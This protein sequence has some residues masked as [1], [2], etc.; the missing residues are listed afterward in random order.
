M[1]AHHLE[2]ERKFEMLDLTRPTPDMTWKIAGFTAQTPVVEDLD[3]TYFD[4][5]TQTLGRHK[6]ALRRRTGG[7]DQGWHIKFDAAGGRHEVTFDLGEGDHIPEAVTDFLAPVLLNEIVEPAVS[8]LT[9][10]VRTVITSQDG[11]DIAEICDDSVTATDFSTGIERRWHEWEIELLDGGVEDSDSAQQ[12]FEAVEK[13][14][15]EAGAAPSTSSAK[16]AR[17]LGA[18]AEF[19][20]RRISQLG[21]EANPKTGIFP[22]PTDK[23]VVLPAAHLLTDILQGFIVKLAQADLLIRAG[24]PDSTHQGR[25]AARQLRSVIKFMAQPY[26]KDADSKALLKGLADGL[27][28]YAHEL[29]P[30]R[31]GELIADLLAEGLENLP[32]GSP[33]HPEAL[34]QLLVAEDTAHLEKALAYITSVTRRDLQADLVQAGRDI[35]EYCNLP[36]NPDNYINKVAKRLRKKLAKQMASLVA[37]LPQDPQG[38]ASAAHLDEQVHDVR[39]LAKATRY[40]LS[41]IRSAGGE[42]TDGQQELLRLAK[43]MQ[44]QQGKLTDQNTLGA[45]L[46]GHQGTLEHLTLGYLLG[47]SDLTAET[48]RLV[49]SASISQQLLDLKKI[50]LS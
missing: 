47:R 7:Y 21:L 6:V 40:S 23:T 15:R 49:V 42:L 8:L 16:I 24:V 9:R 41:A 28:T 32:A 2:V 34:E 22:A 35:T 3:A 43:T 46:L 31:N 17:A 39:K 18:D 37:E 44:G 36:L 20:A 26:A 12:V 50:R 33:V 45:W 10:R 38:R 30:H 11:V 13:L 29:E 27:K 25:V 1:V 14:L 19:E 48:I 4:T 5:D